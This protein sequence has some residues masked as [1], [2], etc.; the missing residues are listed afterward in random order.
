MDVVRV[1]P[2][3]QIRDCYFYYVV[4]WEN[5]W[6]HLHILRMFQMWGSRDLEHCCS[7]LIENRLFHEHPLHSFQPSEIR[8]VKSPIGRTFVF[9]SNFERSQ[10]LEDRR[11]IWNLLQIYSALCSCKLILPIFWTNWW[12]VMKNGLK[13]L[14][15]WSGKRSNHNW[16]ENSKQR[17]FFSLFSEI[18]RGRPLWVTTNQWNNQYSNLSVIR[19]FGHCWE[20]KKAWFRESKTSGLSSGQC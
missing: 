18:A 14:P 5:C 15:W 11:F 10:N 3:F 13:T 20:E 8:E 17:R 2:E 16:K 12:G 9:W 1:F 4:V 7:R 6:Q 19:A